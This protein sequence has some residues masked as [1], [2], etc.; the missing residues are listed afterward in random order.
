[1]TFM[2]EVQSDIAKQQSYL[3]NICEGIVEGIKEGV[4]Q[5]FKEGGKDTL[6]DYLHGNFI[7]PDQADILDI[8]KEI[9]D[10]VRIASRDILEII[11]KEYIQKSLPKLADTDGKE[12]ILE[13]IKTTVR[14][15]MDKHIMDYNPLIKKIFD[16]LKP[17]FE[18]YLENQFEMWKNHP[19]A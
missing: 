14:E 4:I 12:D 9:A 16:V 10:A 8:E 7:D 17:A 1:M 6:K 11:A 15:T 13:L 2:T 3:R 18:S 19:E 5:G